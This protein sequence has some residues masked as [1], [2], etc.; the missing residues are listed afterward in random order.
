[1]LR[2]GEWRENSTLVQVFR[3]G[4]RRQ[5]AWMKASIAT[6]ALAALAAC[7]VSCASA[8][9]MDVLRDPVDGR[10]DT[11]R[12]LLDRKGFL[13]VPI[14]IT[15]PAIGYG[16]GVGLLFFHRN[17]QATAEGRPTPPDIS[18][19]A[20]FGTENGSKGAAAGHLGFSA[21]RRWRY[22]VGAGSASVNLTLYGDSGALA[23]ALPGGV[24]FNLEGTF[25][26]ADV[27]RRFGDSD[28]WA[29]MRYLGAKM[30]ARFG[31]G[32]EDLGFTQRDLATTSS[33]AGVVVEYDGR[34]SIFTPSE[35]IRFKL[36]ALHFSDALGSDR[37]FDHAR[38]SLQ[39]FFRVGTDIVIGLRADAQAVNGDV[40]FYA[41][42][43]IELRGIPLMRYQGSRT[44]LLE[45]EGRMNLDGRW[46]AIAFTGAGRAAAH[47]GDLGS[48]PTRTTVGIGARYLLARALGLHAGIDVARGPEKTAVYLIVGSAW[49]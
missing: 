26:V 36:Q 6:R 8:F 17:E 25:A 41:R 16:G 20:A 2:P 31:A 49:R 24:A 10:F 9:D 28:W 44:A 19:L 13:P 27:R 22:A 7:A 4:D 43:Y 34:D 48:A 5:Y 42:P 35:G 15:E 23:G 30:T 47:A 37:E 18:A 38:G 33:G 1:M 11:S 21:D 46:S 45:V 40:P 39:G 29:G 12:W 32:G 14:V 3:A